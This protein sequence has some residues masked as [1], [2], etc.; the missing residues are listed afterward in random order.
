MQRRRL[1]ASLLLLLLLSLGAALLISLLQGWQAGDSSSSSSSSSSS[2]TTAHVEVDVDSGEFER[3][4]MGPQGAPP[5]RV[6]SAT[7]V[8]A[9]DSADVRRVISSA[10]RSLA[11]VDRVYMM[12]RVEKD[13]GGA[14]GALRGLSEPRL[15]ALAV[16]PWGLYTTPL[17]S[18]LLHAARAGASYMLAISAEVRLTEQ[19]LQ[20]A[21]RAMDAD[22]SLVVA[23]I[24]LPNG[25]VFEAGSKRATGMTIPWNTAALWRVDSLVSP[26]RFLLLSSCFSLH[27]A[28]SLT[29]R[30]HD[31]G[32][33]S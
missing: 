22:D 27:P 29:W 9:R 32:S 14:L 13:S 33:H 12:V 31:L 19:A 16:Q 2:V 24:A 10:T 5:P 6:V 18:A 4:R 21:L 20:C 8:W 7:R 17:N 15:R 11:I 28:D 23:G 25:H 30:R 26:S 3:W 1:A